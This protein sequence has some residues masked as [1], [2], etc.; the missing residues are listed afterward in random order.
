MKQTIDSQ[1][2]NILAPNLWLL[3]STAHSPLFKDMQLSTKCYRHKF[4]AWN[5][6]QTNVQYMYINSL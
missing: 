1:K 3:L 4:G 6:N 5:K 2:Q